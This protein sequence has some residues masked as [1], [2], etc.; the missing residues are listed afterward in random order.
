MKNFVKQTVRQLDPWI[1]VPYLVLCFIGIIMV[2]SSSADMGSPVEF[3]IKQTVFVGLGVIVLM[4]AS[5]FRIS[6]LRGKKIMTCIW[7]IFFLAL[8]LLKFTGKSI[9]GAAGWFT[10]AGISLQPSEFAKL[11]L[12][13]FMANAIANYE[14]HRSNSFSLPIQPPTGSKQPSNENKDAKSWTQSIIFPLIGSAILV[15]LIYL[16]PDLGGAIINGAIVGVLFT[17]SGHFNWKKI[18]LTWA[19]IFF[20]VIL[21]FYLYIAPHAMLPQSKNNY[22]LQRIVAFIHPFKYADSIG[23][24]LVNSYYAISNGGIF[25]SGLGN[26]I[27]KMG[28]LPES[29]TDFIM[30]ITTEELGLVAV[31]LIMLI[32]LLVVLRVVLI[33]IRDD[34]VYYSLICYGVATYITIEMF[35][36]MGGAIGLLPITGVTFPFISYGG[37]SM[38]TLSAGL[39]IVLNIA[40]SQRKRRFGVQVKKA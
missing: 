1:F 31:V 18:V 20:A 9:N 28:Y 14:Q 2:Y 13:L 11:F 12:V 33:G 26:S 23:K 16:Q 37:S 15:V 19:L 22:Q 30:S 4:L 17:I 25:G 27:Q 38:L 3:L 36:N 32:L 24:Q 39:G 40:K 35:F 6:K 5:H 29:N 8:V 21:M 10:I 7:V 34:N